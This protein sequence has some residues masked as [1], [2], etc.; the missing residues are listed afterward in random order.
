MGNLTVP[1]LGRA[2]SALAFG[3]V[4]AAVALISAY[5]IL[6]EKIEDADAAMEA[7]SAEAAKP[8]GSGIEAYR[9]SLDE[10]RTALGKFYA[11][12]KNAG[13]DNDPIKTEIDRARAVADAKIEAEN[14]A[15]QALGLAPV[16]KI[17]DAA[18]LMAEQ[19]D[20]E[21]AAPG[22]LKDAEAKRAAANAAQDKLASDQ[23]AIGIL[24][25][26]LGIGGGG[27]ATFDSEQK[28]LEEL[29]EDQA[30]RQAQFDS[31]QKNG[32]E[33]VAAVARRELQRIEN[34]V[35]G[36]DAD[37]GRRRKLLEQLEGGLSGR[38]Q[39]AADL[40]ISA[41]DAEAMVK[42]NAARL[43]QLPGMTDHAQKVEDTQ[44]QGER[45]ADV[46]NAK[47]GQMNMTLAQ[48]AAATGKSYDQTMN[49][50]QGILNKSGEFER[51]MAQMEAQLHQQGRYLAQRPVN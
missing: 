7:L 14:K 3:P 22:L 23:T 32:N 1:G 35:G 48:L 26:Q 17:G 46:L 49:I 41:D 2:L 44:R 16:Q 21:A 20:R 8:I 15:R 11:E 51:R 4:G 10:A 42:N 37:R 28:K 43:R 27:D 24:R 19:M 47:G 13:V 34:E 29:A 25:K 39:T 36:I 45:V 31:A 38:S 9:A 50:V 12:L 6:R 30:K 40:G 5:K 33:S 18:A